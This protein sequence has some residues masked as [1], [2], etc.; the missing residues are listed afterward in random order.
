[1]RYLL[2]TALLGWLGPLSPIVAQSCDFISCPR[3][4]DSV[5]VLFLGEPSH[6]DEAIFTERL[7]LTRHLH[8]AHGFTL[9]ALEADPFAVAHTLRGGNLRDA[10]MAG[11]RDSPA[12][13]RLT[14]Y[15]SGA[16]KE[17][18][19]VGFDSQL[20]AP[21]TLETMPSRL[22]ERYRYAIEE[23]LQ[24]ISVG[25]RFSP[26]EVENLTQML[27]DLPAQLP[28]GEY[29]WELI[30][31][32][33]SREAYD[34]S[35]PRTGRTSFSVSRPGTGGWQKTFCPSGSKEKK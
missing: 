22:P 29:P 32:N 10:L 30:F 19:V 26:E 8:D 18:R 31:G 33:L 24:R 28:A 23:S 5:D 21:P 34:L 9:L 16:E 27:A 25:D 12:F 35:Q 11:W 1:M 2:L 15:L 14:Q 6:Q 7:L 17:I 3:N 13:V 20:Y 4:V